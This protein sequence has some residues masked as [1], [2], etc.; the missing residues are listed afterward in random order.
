M[1]ITKDTPVDDVLKIGKDC[2][3]CGKCC[4]YGSGFVLDSEIARISSFL[5]MPKEEFIKGFLE[6]IV[7]FNTKVYKIRPH[8]KEAEV[9]GPCTF[10]HDKKCSIHGV[11]PLHCR[12]G[13]CG[14][15]GDDLNVWFMVN[16][17]LNIY[18]PE[19]VR[20][21]KSYIDTGG[22]VIPGA[23]LEKVFPDKRML[24]K[25]LSYERMK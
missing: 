21:Y 19:S 9:Y 1:R 6:E 2:R 23:E 22:R 12:V 5:G 8:K 13:N 17:L 25:I 15:H 14:E 20:Q 18:D 11:K 16:H 3:Q 10:L 7:I 24:K 4:S